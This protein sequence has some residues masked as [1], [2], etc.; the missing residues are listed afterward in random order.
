MNNQKPYIEESIQY[1]RRIYVHNV[2]FEEENIYQLFADFIEVEFDIYPNN[3]STF[4]MYDL[5]LKFS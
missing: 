1:E 2:N 5:L 4:D 3:K